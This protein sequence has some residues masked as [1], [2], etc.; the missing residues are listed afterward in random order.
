MQRVQEQSDLS[1]SNP[2]KNTNVG[3]NLEKCTQND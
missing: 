3:H 2:K 1:S